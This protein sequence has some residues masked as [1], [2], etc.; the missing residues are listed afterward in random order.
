[1]ESSYLDAMHKRLTAIRGRGYGIRPDTIAVG[2]V[3]YLD[4]RP[5]SLHTDLRL[6][7]ERA[8]FLLQLKAE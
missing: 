2:I 5:V 6:S 1:M 3:K 7:P 8:D 4:S